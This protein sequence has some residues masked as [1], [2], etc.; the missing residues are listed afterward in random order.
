[1][2]E[3]KYIQNTL[4]LWLSRTSY[5]WLSWSRYHPLSLGQLKEPV[6][7]GMY[8]LPVPYFNHWTN[9][10]LIIIELYLYCPC[11]LA[12]HERLA[13]CLVGLKWIEC[14]PGLAV[15]ASILI[16][17]NRKIVGKYAGMIFFLILGK[18]S[19]NCSCIHCFVTL[20]WEHG[21]CCTL[22][23]SCKQSHND[24]SLIS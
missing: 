5:L 16:R 22:Q 1:M 6:Y 11:I 20:N 19:G 4:W 9:D 14:I 17:P 23:V 2:T 18:H 3:I 10:P 24:W 12:Q 7:M 21:I 15:N 8:G 13:S